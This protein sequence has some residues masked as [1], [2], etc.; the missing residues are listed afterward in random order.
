MTVELVG[1]NGVLWT[2]KGG[3]PFYG[4]MV[5]GGD[6]R[7]RARFDPKLAFPPQFSDL[8]SLW[9]SDPPAQMKLATALAPGREDRTIVL[10][11]DAGLTATVTVGGAPRPSL[12]PARRL[13]DVVLQRYLVTAAERRTGVVIEAVIDLPPGAEAPRRVDL[14]EEPPC[15][16]GS[17]GAA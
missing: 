1:R 17:D 7:M 8:Q 6:A 9:S 5:H 10:L 16:A 14:Y 15:E 4:Q 12:E 11:H 13:D 2:R 3:L